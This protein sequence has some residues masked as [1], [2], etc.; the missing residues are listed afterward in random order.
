M[1]EPSTRIVND[2]LD[3]FPPDED[4]QPE[5]PRQSKTVL[6]VTQKMAVR[7]PDVDSRSVIIRV[8]MVG[9]SRVVADS[10][11]AGERGLQAAYVR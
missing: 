10:M 9:S 11:D 7:M 2:W 8:I 3:D 5:R 4:P 1:S 6:A